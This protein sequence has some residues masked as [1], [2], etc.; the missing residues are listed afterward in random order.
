MEPQQG[1]CGLCCARTRLQMRACV[2]EGACRDTAAKVDVWRTRVGTPVLRKEYEDCECVGVLL[3][4]RRR[5]PMRSP[6]T[7]EEPVCTPEF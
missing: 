4:A 5:T 1:S 7:H 6:D 3:R 2:H